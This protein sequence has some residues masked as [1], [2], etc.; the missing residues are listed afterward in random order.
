MNRTK[1]F[2]SV[3]VCVV[4]LIAAFSI[5]AYADKPSTH[6]VATAAEL[7]EVLDNIDNY[8]GETIII[9][10]DIDM[11]S[12]AGKYTK[13]L[14]NSGVSFYTDEKDENYNYMVKGL[15]VAPFKVTA[16]LY[17]GEYRT[18]QL[19][20]PVSA[21][22]WYTNE[23]GRWLYMD[24]G[25]AK[26]GWIQYKGG[27]YYLD[28]ANKGIASVGW[29]LIN[30]KYYYFQADGLMLT[31]WQSIGGKWYYFNNSGAMV[32]GWAQ[33]GGKW[34]YFNKWGAMVTGWAQINGKWYY[35]NNSGAMVTGWAQIGGK[36]YYMNSSG[37][38]VTGW[39][40]IGGKWYYFNNSGAMVTGW[41]QIGGKWYYMNS[42]GAMVTG[43]QRING[44]TYRFNTSGVWVA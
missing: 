16:G 21:S 3:V 37:A 24:K 26:T 7:A 22:G 10:A 5:A 6:Y 2:I 19:L 38:M 43:T 32:T 8:K 28:P 39:A 36:W 1:K 13:D 11:S 34:Y 18:K 20:A 9:T 15:N 27:W 35:F 23:D 31:G 4:A 17:K 12:Y 29:E 30:G 42:S 41:A 33:I 40:Q 25:Y 44:K 14:S